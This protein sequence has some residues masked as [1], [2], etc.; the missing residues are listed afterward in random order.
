MPD[1]GRTA[2]GR[3]DYEEGALSRLQWSRPSRL[4]QAC[5]GC[6]RSGPFLRRKRP[7]AQGVGLAPVSSSPTPGGRDK[8]KS[9][10]HHGLCPPPSLPPIQPP[11]QVDFNAKNEYEYIANYKVLQEA[12]NKLNIDKVGPGWGEAGRH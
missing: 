12:F 5:K 1:D 7:A 3:G 8:G 11:S 4:Q 10:G 9:A 2:P 6:S